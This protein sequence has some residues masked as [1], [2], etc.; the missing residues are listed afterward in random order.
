MKHRYQ[1]SRLSLFLA[2]PVHASAQHEHAGAGGDQ[3]GSDSVSFHDVVRACPAAGFQSRRR[4]PAFVLVRAGDRGVRR[5]VGEGPLVRDGPLG[6]GAQ[7]MGQSICRA[8]LAAADR[9]RAS[10]HSDARRR[11]ARRRRAS[12]RTSPPPPSCLRAAT[13]RPSARAPSPTS[14]AWNGSCANFPGDME[15]RIFYALAVNQTALASDKKYS[16]QLKAAAILEPLFKEHPKHPGLAHYI[17]HAYDHPPLAEKAL[18]GRAQLCVSRAVGTARA[19]HA[20]AYVY[21]R[22]FVE[23]IDR[24]QS[25]IRRGGAQRERDRRRAARDGLPDIRISADRRR[26]AMRGE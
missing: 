17:I 16:Q 20:V 8:S 19:A 9:A 18:D 3:V 10:R 7:P 11:R 24:D 14:R 23:G 25:P 15:A 26:M 21:A 22:R 13:P 1:P 6:R 2:L 12:A 5:R 4:A